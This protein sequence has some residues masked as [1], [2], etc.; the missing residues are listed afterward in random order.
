M[1]KKMY[2]K[3]RQFTK[4]IHT[5]IALPTVWSNLHKSLQAFFRVMCHMLLPSFFLSS[6][7]SVLELTT[8]L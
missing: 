6:N 1:E 4:A 7:D 5:I 2:S 8:Q 3:Y